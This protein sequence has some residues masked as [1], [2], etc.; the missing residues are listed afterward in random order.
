MTTAALPDGGTSAARAGLTAREAALTELVKRR[1]MARLT[2][3]AL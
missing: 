1:L 3:G 2:L